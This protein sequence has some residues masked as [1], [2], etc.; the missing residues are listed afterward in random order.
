MESEKADVAC[1]L[2]LYKCADWIIHHQ[3]PQALRV[4]QV[5]GEV[6]SDF[7]V[8]SGQFGNLLN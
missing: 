6:I 4:I 3:A 1:S 7:P 2:S 8:S 5:N